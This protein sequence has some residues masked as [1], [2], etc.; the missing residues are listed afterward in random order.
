[1]QGRRDTD[2]M[3]GRAL[4][5]VLLFSCVVCAA[6]GDAPAGDGQDGGTA[7]DL[8]GAAVDGL[9]K[10]ADPFADRIVSYKPGE[11]AGF[12]QALL[13]QVVL[14]APDGGGPSQSGLDVLSLGRGGEIVLEFTDIGLVD[15]PGPDLLVFENPFVGW[16]ETGV[17]AVSDDG[18]T[19]AEWPCDARDPA[20]KFPG[21]AGVNPVLSSPKNGIPA[22]D[23]ARSGGDAF[24]LA[25]LGV[26]RAR[27]VR[28][29]DSGANTYGGNTGGFDLDAV[30][31]VNG[32]P[33]T[34]R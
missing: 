8:Q 18:V 29:R 33:I 12:G 19:W 7:Q 2:G 28:V 14:G 16:T 20:K 27:F 22:T 15:G 30:A 10:A 23:P 6:C 32:E 11:A 13:P 4:R 26:A 25:A 21:C 17:V 9:P 24:D 1:M 3:P 34:P 5:M 31:V